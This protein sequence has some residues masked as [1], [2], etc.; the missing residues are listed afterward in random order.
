LA[1]QKKAEN[2]ATSLDTTAAETEG[3]AGRRKKRTRKV[4]KPGKAKRPTLCAVTPRKRNQSDSSGSNLSDGSIS[5]R[6]DLSALDCPT[7]NLLNR[8]HGPDAGN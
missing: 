5:D 4:A 1:A 3:E 7:K 6:E 8:S 2:D